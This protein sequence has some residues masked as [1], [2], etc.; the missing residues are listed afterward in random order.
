MPSLKFVAAD[1]MRHVSTAPKPWWNRFRGSQ[2]RWFSEWPCQM[3][4]L[5]LGVGSP[6]QDPRHQCSVDVS[7][8]EFQHVW[9]TVTCVQIN[10]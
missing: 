7:L 3:W 8:P 9:S 5:L 10:Q 6:T 2:T 4:S 1:C